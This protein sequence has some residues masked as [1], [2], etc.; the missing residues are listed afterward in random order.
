MRQC[1]RR[2]SSRIYLW[3]SYQGKGSIS[4]GYPLSGPPPSTW[5]FPQNTKR[6]FLKLFLQL[7]KYQNPKVL[8]VSDWPHPPLTLKASPKSII[9]ACAHFISMR[10]SISS[11][12]GLE[13]WMHTWCEWLNHVFLHNL[14]PLIFSLH[15]FFVRLLLL[16]ICILHRFK[17][18]KFQPC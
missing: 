17:R 3:I 14:W 13:R 1:S 7:F 18:R 12:Y 15:A 2:H 9:E 5:Q 4:L 16:L 10:I 11:S 8:Q 6:P